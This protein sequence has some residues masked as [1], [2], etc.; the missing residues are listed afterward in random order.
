MTRQRAAIKAMARLFSGLLIGRSSERS[1][2]GVSD[3]REA[4]LRADLR[5][6]FSDYSFAL[7]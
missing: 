4:A 2:C 6:S 7:T 1:L 3:W 5:G